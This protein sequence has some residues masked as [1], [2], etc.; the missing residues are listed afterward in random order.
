MTRFVVTR[1]GQSIANAERRFAGIS[2]FDLT[3]IGR[4][5]ARLTAKYICENEKI[6]V[7]YSSDLSRAYNTALPTSEILGMKIIPLGEL[8]EIFAG[9][10]EGLSTVDI[11]ERFSEDFSVWRDD[12]ANC[13]CT[14]GE[15]TKEVYARIMGLIE[16]LAKENDGKT[17]LLSTHATLVRAL[18]ANAQGLS[19]DRTGE[20]PFNHN[21]SVSIFT[22]ENGKL[23]PERLD[24]TEHLGDIV[25]GVHHSFNKGKQE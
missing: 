20:I 19:A 25:T 11:A 4:E 16:R 15:S 2:D 14:G 22:Y 8:R 21:A 24:I 13:R 23:T 10:W 18:C 5:Q 3:D 1:H 17:V 6:D 9:D 12:Y 7:I